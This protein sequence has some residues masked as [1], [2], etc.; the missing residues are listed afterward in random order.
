VFNRAPAASDFPEALRR[1]VTIAAEAPSSHNCQPW[2]LAWIRS[3]AALAAAREHFGFEPGERALVLALDHERA[4]GS[5]VFH[6]TEMQLSCGIYLE[7]LVAAL[8]AAGWPCSLA[9]AERDPEPGVTLAAPGWPSTWR[10]LVLVRARRGDADP[11]AERRLARRLARRITNR[12]PYQARAIPDDV[13]ADLAARRAH[14]VTDAGAIAAAADLV[15]ERATL[16]FTYA[17]AWRETH[18][19][20]RWPGDARAVDGLPVSHL[21]GPLSRGRAAALRATL[22]PPLLGRFGVGYAER[23]ARGLGALVAASPALLAVSLPRRDRT[24]RTTLAAG[25]QIL[26]LWL[27][28]TDHGLALHPISVMVQHAD[29]SHRLAEA[30]SVPA[31]L[32]FFARVGYPTT[33]FP[34]APRRRD[35]AV[36]DL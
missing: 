4:L 28:A 34:R 18:R 12:A 14:L 33:T 5:L 27:R 19:F 3:A 6:R 23:L 2:G 1:A 35:G 16:D 9:W 31:P 26:D 36:L 8:G 22:W 21:F 20:L 30:L 10:P 7:A 13:V 11:A 32:C 25:A 29:P 15:A 17:A 24:A